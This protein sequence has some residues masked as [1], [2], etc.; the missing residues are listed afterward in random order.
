MSCGFM[1]KLTAIIYTK[2][3]PISIA[4]EMSKRS[5]T[6]RWD[7]Y[8]PKV[9]KMSG[10]HMGKV[11]GKGTYSKVCLAI[12]PVTQKK[13][14]C[15]IINKKSSGDEYIQKFLP[16][17]LKIISFIDHPN[18]VSFY[19]VVQSPHNVYVFM[20]YCK[21]GDLL[22]YIREHGAFTEEKTRILFKQVLEAVHY[23]H[24]LDV[25]HRDIKCENI[26]LVST[27]R[28]K[29]GDFGFARYCIN[30]FGK[31]IL[32][33][34]FCGS[35]AYAAPEI[36]QGK[37]YDPKKY[38]IW[39]LGCILYVMV[40]ASM[41]FDDTDIRQMVKDQMN[42]NIKNFDYFWEWC[43]ANMKRLIILLLEPNMS[44]RINTLQISNHP[45]IK[46]NEYRR[47][48]RSL[49]SVSDSKLV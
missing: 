31:K 1:P 8:S 25:A 30:E 14:A 39:A 36:L 18:I 41:P 23:L 16:R 34:T 33:N 11:I 40:T 24:C 13:V 45:W 20:D 10:Y 17:E 5:S 2:F 42:R 29:L 3:N 9:S 6:K 22:E 32:S 7:R 48:R 12:N 26:F 28:V 35:A 37:Y 38:D 27:N 21:Y 43:S 44:L 46:S 47:S 4:C 19:K 15:K 49:L